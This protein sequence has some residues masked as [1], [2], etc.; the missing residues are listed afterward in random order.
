MSQEL[1]VL[2][3]VSDRQRLN[4]RFNELRRLSRRLRYLR[5]LK[6]K[7]EELHELNGRW[8]E[9]NEVRYGIKQ[10]KREILHFKELCSLPKPSEI[11]VIDN[12]AL[13]ELLSIKIPRVCPETYPC[14]VLIKS[15]EG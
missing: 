13:K 5:K 8:Q 14:G 6:A 1:V 12:E 15:L 4:A 7:D 11:L 10:L 2:K 9:E 3:K